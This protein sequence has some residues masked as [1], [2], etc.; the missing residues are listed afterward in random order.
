MTVYWARLGGARLARAENTSLLPALWHAWWL[1][2]ARP[3]C[4]RGAT[5]AQRGLALAQLAMAALVCHM[6]P[7][8][9]LPADALRVLAAHSNPRQQLWHARRLLPARPICPRGAIL[10]Q[11]GLAHAAQDLEALASLTLS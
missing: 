2:P 10:A 7:G 9:A 1:L 3:I 5:L 4:P 6:T 8:R 11:Q